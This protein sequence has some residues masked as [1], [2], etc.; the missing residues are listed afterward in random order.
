MVSNFFKVEKS[1]A[2]KSHLNLSAFEE[3]FEIDKNWLRHDVELNKKFASGSWANT[4]ESAK[5]K[6][7]INNL[8][9]ITV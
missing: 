4:E 1:S 7:I 3:V 6:T 5:A 8:N 9:A 2:Q